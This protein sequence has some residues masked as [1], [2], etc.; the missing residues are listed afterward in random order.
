[1]ILRVFKGFAIKIFWLFIIILKIY[2]SYSAQTQMLQ[3]FLLLKI[4]RRK[5]N[6]ARKAMYESVSAA[7]FVA[8]QLAFIEKWNGGLRLESY[9]FD[10][11]HRR[12]EKKYAHRRIDES[13]LKMQ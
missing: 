12:R 10:V 3:I 8:R 9:F 2:F 5:E 7:F 4:F 13:P 11:L 1:M 6:C